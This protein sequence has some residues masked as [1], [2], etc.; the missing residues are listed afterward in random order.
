M[1]ITSSR[2]IGSFVAYSHYFY[3]SFFKSILDL[4]SFS[5]MIYCDIIVVVNDHLS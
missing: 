2:V 5:V 3:S 1:Y 4:E